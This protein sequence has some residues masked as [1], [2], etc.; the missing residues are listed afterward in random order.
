[1]PD[2][3]TFLGKSNEYNYGAGRFYINTTPG[4]IPQGFPGA[5][6]TGTS[7]GKTGGIT[8]RHIEDTVDMTS[9]QTG[10]G[11]DDKRL[12]YQAVE[13]E[14]MIKEGAVEVLERGL[15]GL[16]AI[17][18]TAGTLNQIAYVQKLGYGDRAN[19]IRCT[20]VEIDEGR[21]VWDE[22]LRVVDFLIAAPSIQTLEAVYDAENQR[23]YPMILKCY[24]DDN[25]LD[26]DGRPQFYL[27]REVVPTP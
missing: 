7:L 23:E 9:S 27:T 4:F 26:E 20:F 25:T 6:G 3:R 21:E 16:K 24:P 15:K 8:I 12:S 22:P 14:T 1:M 5:S 18:D 17:R 2:P 19:A 11:A 10:N 13:V